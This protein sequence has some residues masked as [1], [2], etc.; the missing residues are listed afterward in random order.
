M[1][2]LLQLEHLSLVS[3]V[4]TEL[5]NHLNI[6]DKSVAEFIIDLAKKNATFDRFKK[7]L[8]SF[9]LN[10]L[11]D[12]LIHHLLRLVMEMQPKKKKKEHPIKPISDEKED[13]KKIFPKL[14]MPN[15][16]PTD[17]LNQLEN[18][19]GKWQ[20]EQVGSKLTIA[21]QPIA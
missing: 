3:R 17:L 6:D 15:T 21:A 18:L 7:A 2:D 13:L 5:E 4:L 14:A 12:S 9:D 20:K 19:E 8:N 1:D 11:D 10:D 16:A